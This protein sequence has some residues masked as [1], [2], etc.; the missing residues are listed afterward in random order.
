MTARPHY[1][2]R[3]IILAMTRIAT[4]VF[5]T[6]EE[7]TTSEAVQADRQKAAQAQEHGKPYLSVAKLLVISLMTWLAFFI[8]NLIS[9]RASSTRSIC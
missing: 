6:T 4:V 9:S 5:Q 1:C 8:E 7:Q 3:S 2:M